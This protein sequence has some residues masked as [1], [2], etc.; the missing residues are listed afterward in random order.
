[1]LVPFPAAEPAIAFSVDDSK[2]RLEGRA[3]FVLI[4]LLSW[5]GRAISLTGSREETN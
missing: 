5:R 3:G 1:M 2:E 4:R